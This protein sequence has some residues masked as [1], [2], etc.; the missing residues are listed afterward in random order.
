MKDIKLAM[1]Q[2]LVSDKKE[3]NIEKA[4][5][6]IKKAA[7]EGAHLAVL[8]EMFNCPYDNSFFESF[9][10]QGIDG[11]TMIAIRA[12]ARDNDIC[13]IAGSIP[14]K[15]GE[16]IYNTSH[17]VDRNGEVIASHR[18]MHLFDI[19]I[20]NGIRF[21]ESDVLSAGDKVTL[22][23]TG[24]GRIGIGI[25]YDIRFF[26]LACLMADEG[27]ELLVYP[28]AFN[29][30]TGPAHWELLIRSRAVDNQVFVLA[31]SPARNEAAS[32]TAYGHSML[33]DPFGRI[34]AKAGTGEELVYADLRG[35]IVEEI[36]E[37]LPVRMHKRKDIYKLLKE[38]R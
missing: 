36:R 15:D 17:Y 32:Y 29:M 6:M 5:M 11:E 37:Q 30:T 26:E 25:C 8:P 27:A 21:K 9:S 38:S 3:V 16:N 28:A 19:N 7:C 4:V 13:V 24:Y 10:E 14:E 31:V 12:V 18:K 23:D 20:K 33:A 35:A 22:V 2:M 34:I 1:C